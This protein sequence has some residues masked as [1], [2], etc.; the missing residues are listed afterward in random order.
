[1]LTSLEVRTQQGAVLSLPL[2]ESD[3]GFVVENL[4]GLDPVKATLVSSSFA[5]MDGAQYHSSRR[6]PR[7]IRLR[8]GLE[9]EGSIGSVREL[10][11]LLYG[12]LMPKTQVTLR[13]HLVEGEGPLDYLDLDI[14]GRVESMETPLFVQEPAVEISLMC[15][16][17][18]FRDIV[19]VNT[20]N[21][22]TAGLT[23]LNLNYPGTVETGVEFILKPNRDISAFTIYHRPA[24]GTLRTLDF[25]GQLV[26]G[27][28]VKIN[29]SRGQKSVTRVRN[30]VE[31]PMLYAL[32]PQSNW[33]ELQPGPNAY[34][35]YI[36]GA[37][38]PFELNYTT[39][40][41]GL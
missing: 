16:D 24:D 41:G 1:M 25:T 13:F 37:Q 18:D 22:S 4:E 17:P 12:F 31:T 26:A 33:M 11:K 27:D 23:E 7:N 15:F 29:T 6:E 2:D 21:F 39:R 3:L 28:V 40:Y 36:E 14:L 9:A 10:R 5:N 19:R 30:G 20:S 8:L 35:V 34:R 32:S 38:I